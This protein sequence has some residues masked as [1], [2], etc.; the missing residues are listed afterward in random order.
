M[1]P[2][3]A[4]CL[5]L[6]GKHSGQADRQTDRQTWTEAHMVFFVHVTVWRTPKMFVCGAT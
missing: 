2:S 4:G 1:T 5:T 6:Q 3:H